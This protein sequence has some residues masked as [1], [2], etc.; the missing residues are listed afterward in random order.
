M[1][2]QRLQPVVIEIKLDCIV[3][4]IWR[5]QVLIFQLNTVNFDAVLKDYKKGFVNF[6]QRNQEAENYLFVE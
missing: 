2:R 3:W 5:I 1:I 6:L 4:Q